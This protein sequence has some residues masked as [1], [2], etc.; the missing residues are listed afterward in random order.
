M[1]LIR[2][3]RD[4]TESFTATEAFEEPLML[5]LY[6][7]GG[8]TFRDKLLARV[9]DYMELSEHDLM[10]SGRGNA[11]YSRAERALNILVARGYVE[12]KKRARGDD[13]YEL[14]GKG[15]VHVRA[16][17]KEVRG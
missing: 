17:L 12:K 10:K 14:T 16:S 2:V 5:A 4:Y 9:A 1:G 8:S 7:M 3:M 15:R 11:Y 13:V 6:K